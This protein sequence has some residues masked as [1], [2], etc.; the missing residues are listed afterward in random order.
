MDHLDRS[1]R[2][3]IDCILFEIN[4]DLLDNLVQS[5]IRTVIECVGTWWRENGLLLKDRVQERFQISTVEF[6]QVFLR[7]FAQPLFEVNVFTAQLPIERN[8]LLSQDQE[9]LGS[10]VESGQHPDETG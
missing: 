3:F 8:R 10:R 1:Q 9:R 2:L 4:I 7:L 5:I 6:G